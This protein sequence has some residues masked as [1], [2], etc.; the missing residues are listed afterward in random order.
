MW[1]P[2]YDG[3]DV[4]RG[5]LW[6]EA[7]VL[8]RKAVL[9]IVGTFLGS[10]SSGVPV[11]SAV[12]LVS[13]GLQEAVHPYEEPRFNWGERVSLGGA[14]AASL[15]ATLY[16]DDGDPARNGNLAVT[17]CITFVT[18]L[19]LLAL[20][21][22]WVGEA[23]A[24]FVGLGSKAR[25]AIRLLSVRVGSSRLRFAAASHRGHSSRWSVL[26][27]HGLT[28]GKAAGSSAPVALA[29]SLARQHRHGEP[30]TLLG[31]A[32]VLPANQRAR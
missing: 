14:L 18:V 9:A 23:R 6:W 30:S 17:A 19:V 5:T 4:Q 11:L 16:G 28:D 21:L 3:Y 26:V 12:L 15:L 8:L 10:N 13:L 7:V 1:R 22:Q 25:G 32:R 27:L 29:G 20:A 31:T 24:N 2:L